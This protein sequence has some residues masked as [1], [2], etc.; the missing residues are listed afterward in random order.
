MYWTV[1][2]GPWAIKLGDLKTMR[3]IESSINSGGFN[4]RTKGNTAVLVAQDGSTTTVQATAMSV[5]KVDPEEERIMAE[6][7][8][9]M[10]HQIIEE[11][12][13][14]KPVLE[15]PI[16]QYWEK[17]WI[18]KHFMQFMCGHIRGDTRYNGSL[19]AFAVSSSQARGQILI[20]PLGGHE[21]ELLITVNTEDWTE[22]VDAY[23]SSVRN[24][25]RVSKGIVD[26]ERMRLDK[27]LSPIVSILESIGALKINDGTALPA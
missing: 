8:D 26:M 4:S 3:E 14:Q 22:Y 6:G 13:E 18:D 1:D 17:G 19:S 11:E 23:L 5:E 2:R 12:V 24:K 15:M 25:V 16:S 7:V 27:A 9:E 20:S 10:V 21:D